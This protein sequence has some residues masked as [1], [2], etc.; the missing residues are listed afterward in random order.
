MNATATPTKSMINGIDREGLRD[1]IAACTANPAHAQTRWAVTTRWKGGTVTETAVDHY[2]F[3]GRRVDKDFV[4]RTDEPCELGGTNTLPNPQETLMAALN[5]CM[6][7]G[8]AAVAT[9]MGVRL[10]KIEI[11]TT[12]DIDLRGFLGID[13]TVKPGYDSIKYTVHLKGD[14]TPEQFA[15]MHEI[16]CRTSPNRFNIANAIRLDAELVVE[17]EGEE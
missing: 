10:E 4:I 5:A 8:Y 11:H 15:K 14:G 3:A 9:V 2:E 16:V 6:T 17:G 12:G 13:E 1:L 7:V